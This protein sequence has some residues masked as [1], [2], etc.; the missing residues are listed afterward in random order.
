MKYYQI[1][2]L[3]AALIICSGAAL[4][5]AE[6]GPRPKLTNER[7]VRV[8]ATSTSGRAE[9]KLE[10]RASSTRRE[11]RRA[12][13]TMMRGSS[14]MMQKIEDRRGKMCENLETRI[15]NRLSSFGQRYDMHKKVYD[16]HKEKLLQLSSKLDINA[17]STIKLKAD[18]AILDAKIAD[19]EE[20]HAKVKTALEAT[21]SKA[22]GDNS[23]EFKAAVEAVRTQQKAVAEQAKDI[24]QFI[25]GTIRQD[26]MAIRAELNKKSS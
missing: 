20:E 16:M 23:G 21:K 22:C 7:E 10:D 26:M 17:S 4:V 1:T 11:D 6:Q 9:L 12:S 25:K 13:S 2:A 3:V 5:H 14:T 8:R 19:F 24:Y 15:N 18:I